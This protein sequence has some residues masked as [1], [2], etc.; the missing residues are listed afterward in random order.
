MFNRIPLLLFVLAGLSWM[1]LQGCTPPPPPEPEV[2]AQLKEPTA[3]AKVDL[4]TISVEA[5]SY[6]ELTEKIKEYKGKVVV[7]DYW[8]TWCPEC[9]AEFPGLVELH[10]SHGPDEV[11]C[12]SVSL[13]ADGG[14]VEE[15]KPLVLEFLREKQANFPNILLKTGQRELRDQLDD[16]TAPPTMVVY[17]QEGELAKLFEAQEATYEQV[18]PFVEELLEK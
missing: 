4:P 3:P 18:T 1:G 5:M 14:D 13:D 10:Q 8:A 17:N 15:V 2:E 9:V 16:F 11:V 6:D 7:L 12:V